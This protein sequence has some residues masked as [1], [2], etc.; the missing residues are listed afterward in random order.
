M[1]ALLALERNLWRKRLDA[2]YTRMLRAVLNKSWKQHPT[3]QNLYGHL[4]PISQT[5]QA[6]RARHA[7]HCRRSKDEF[8]SNVL[9]WT[10]TQKHS[11]INRAAETYIHQ[12]C[13]DTGCR[14][15]DLSRSIR[16]DCERVRV[17]VI[18]EDDDDADDLS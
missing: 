10:P 11:S 14:L 2:N 6:R 5:I 4:T 1:V 13:K 18:L 17:I 12:L 9:P 7:S 8:I 15:D 3:K 16:T